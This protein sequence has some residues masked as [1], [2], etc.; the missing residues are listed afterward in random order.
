VF[1]QAFFCSGEG[2]QIVVLNHPTLVNPLGQVLVDTAS[3]G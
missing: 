3:L 1:P 2:K